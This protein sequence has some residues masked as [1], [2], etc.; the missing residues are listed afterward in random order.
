MF[1]FELNIEINN[2]N[3]RSSFKGFLFFKLSENYTTERTDDL[4]QVA[5]KI[6]TPRGVLMTHLDR[7]KFPQT[8]FFL[9]LRK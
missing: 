3:I 8:I 7:E 6:I 9:I 2:F 5:E 1:V 4:K